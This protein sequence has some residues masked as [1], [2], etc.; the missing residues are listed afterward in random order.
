MARTVVVM[1]TRRQRLGR[2]HDHRLARRVARGPP[3]PRGRDRGAARTDRRLP[4][5]RDGRL[6]PVRPPDPP[7]LDRTPADDDRRAG[8]GRPDRGEAV[9]LRGAGRRP[10]REVA[11]RRR[12]RSRPLARS[13]LHHLADPLLPRQGPERQGRPPTLTSRACPL[14]PV[15]RRGASA[16]PA[17]GGP[18]DRRHGDRALPRPRAAGRR[19]RHDGRGRWAADPAAAA[20]V[21]GQPLAQRPGP[22]APG[23]SGAESCSPARSREELGPSSGSARSRSGAARCASSPEAGPARTGGSDSRWRPPRSPPPPARAD[24]PAPAG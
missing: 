16:R 9:P 18:R 5:L 24:R 17:E 1:T 22:S 10:A 13:V 21:R 3:A 20:P 12:L 6:R 7:R 2:Q 8:P 4:K 19:R 15:P 14:P 11:R 23:R